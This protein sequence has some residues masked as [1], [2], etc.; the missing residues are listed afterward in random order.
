MVYRTPEMLISAML[1]SGSCGS[2]E[3]PNAKLA[4]DKYREERM[5]LDR[6][7]SIPM[8]MIGSFAAI[9]ALAMT[10]SILPFEELFNALLKAT[11]C[12]DQTRTSHFMKWT[13]L[14]LNVYE[15]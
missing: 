10:M 6:K 4:D 1:R 3:S 15:A 8:A 13:L 5:M 9:P 2:S 11:S 14:I 12:S 7:G